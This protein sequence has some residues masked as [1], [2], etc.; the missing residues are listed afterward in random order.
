M[1]ATDPSTITPPHLEVGSTSAASRTARE[2]APDEGA[3][4][5]ILAAPVET[6]PGIGKVSGKALSERGL[7]SVG[8]LVWLLPRR[9]DDRRLVTPIGRLTPGA[10]LLTEGVVRTVTQP[11]P[12]GRKRLSEVRLVPRPS[13]PSGHYGQLRLVWFHGLPGLAQRFPV[14]ATVRVFGRV[15][16][17]RGVLTIAH[18]E[19][20]N[21][22]GA[23]VPR[24][25][26]IP[27]VTPAALRKALAAALERVGAFVPD[28]IPNAVRDRGALGPVG[29][30]LAALHA[31]PADLDPDAL[32]TWNAGDTEH[33]GRLAIE[34]LFLLELALQQRRA[35]EAGLPA[36]ACVAPADVCRAD[37]G[38]LPFSLTEDQRR[39]LGDVRRDLAATTPMRRMLQGEVGS[40]KTAVA[41]LASAQVAHVGAQIAWL[42]PTEVLAEQHFRGITRLAEP[43]GL[44]PVLMAGKLRARERRERLASIASGEANII[45]GTHALLGEAVQ[46]D[47]LAAV[48]VDEQHRF[49]VAQRLQL[50][51]KAGGRAPHL[52][53]M[54][55]TPIPRSLALA[56]YGDLEVSTMRGLPPGRK[57]IIT[58]RYASSGRGEAYR[59]LERALASGGRA[60]VVCPTIAP[61]SARGREDDDE[62]Q[63]PSGRG[64]V[65]VHQELSARLDVPVAMLHA[66]LDREA[67]AEALGAFADGRVTVL[68]ATTIVEVG[69]DVPEANVIVVEDADRFGLAQLHQLR[70]RVGRGERQSACLLVHADA[71]TPDAE[72][73]LAAMCATTD[74]FELAER[75]LA[76]RG[77]GQLF[78]VRQAGAAGFRF[79][80]L[81]RDLERLELARSLARALH[82]DDPSLSAPHHA[83][84]RHA[85]R[86]VLEQAIVAEESG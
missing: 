13:D 39:V 15:D 28:I 4:D 34:E 41:L 56:L 70:G 3:I 67:R 12:R 61:A 22:A 7:S 29:V 85:V 50:V 23:I 30:A 11:P 63:D 38:K 27:G 46:F 73:R 80:D 18:P 65:A 72:L 10:R 55:A 45:V 81:F 37:E 21:E 32:V 49:G 44:R 79:A 51:D 42:V 78:G 33:H 9:Y 20:P 14:G 6:L 53:V 62:E 5:A 52:L 82:A 1:G 64:V 19:L 74:G 24:Y 60:F 83:R 58:K 84:A 57:P 66:K 43:M 76:I 75:D 36:R 48:V 47:D 17:H 35:D 59:Q 25:P 71:L 2:G 26:A 77:P 16:E 31:P 40:G 86:R 68:V 8:D 54:T 69:V